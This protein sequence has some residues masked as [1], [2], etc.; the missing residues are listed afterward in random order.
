MHQNPSVREGH[1]TSHSKHC[2]VSLSL[3]TPCHILAISLF[4]TALYVVGI[5]RTRTRR[6]QKAN[7][8]RTSRTCRLTSFRYIEPL[9]QRHN[10]ANIHFLSTTRTRR[11]LGSV[12]CQSSTIPDAYSCFIQKKLLRRTARSKKVCLCDNGLVFGLRDELETNE[13]NRGK[14][15]RNGGEQTKHDTSILYP[16]P[17][18]MN[19]FEHFRAFSK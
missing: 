3:I 11:R 16:I 6:E 14:N 7:L 15:G 18:V 13:N 9:I 12:L 17:A 8:M 5:G 4:S 10:N 1:R 2:P 19:R